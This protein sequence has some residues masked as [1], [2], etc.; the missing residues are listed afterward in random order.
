VPLAPDLGGSEH[1]ARAAHVTERSLTGTVSSSTRD[2]GN[3]SDGTSSTPGLGRSLVTSLLGAV[4]ALEREQ[5]CVIRGVL[6]GVW[7]AAVLVHAS[8]DRVDNVRAD[9]R[10][11]EVSAIVQRFFLLHCIAM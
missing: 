10:L 3:T 5:V 4:A 7:L 1:A 6:H 11:Y 9:G 8:V 2:T